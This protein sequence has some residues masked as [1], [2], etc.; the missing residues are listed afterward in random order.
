MKT[1]IL[2]ALLTATIAIGTLAACGARQGERPAA[3][4]QTAGMGKP[5]YQLV[6]TQNLWNFIK[7]NTANGKMWLV[8]YSVDSD[9]NRFQVDLNRQSLLPQ[10]QAEAG[11]RFTLTPTANLWNFILL[12]QTDGRQWQV[13]WSTDGKSNMVVPID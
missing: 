10:G 9:E 6:A 2:S 13:Q 11:G 8:Q 5:V 3:T 12:D 7:L 1:T 4:T